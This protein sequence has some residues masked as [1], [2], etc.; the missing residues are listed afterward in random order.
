[1]I[2]PPKMPPQPPPQAGFWLRAG[3][4]SL[5]LFGIIFV[6]LLALFLSPVRP[7]GAMV[8]LFF[9]VAYVSYFTL[10]PVH[11]GGQTLGKMAAGIAIRRPD[12]SPLTYVHTFF[13]CLGYTISWLP[14]GL[15][16]LAAAVTP[17]GRA[18]HDY[19]VGTWVRETAPAGILRKT[20]VVSATLLLA[21]PLFGSM[22]LRA[23]LER[24]AKRE[25][26]V[27]A[28]P[29]P[30]PVERTARAMGKKYVPPPETRTEP[31]FKPRPPATGD[32][33]ATIHNLKRL[34][35]RR[36]AYSMRYGG[37]KPPNLKSLISVFLPE[38]PQ[39][40]TGHHPATASVQFFGKDACLRE[41]VARRAVRD[42]GAWGYVADK[43]ASCHG[44]IFVDCVH[45][46]SRRT[47]WFMH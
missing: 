18:L 32:D 33:A 43:E 11:C 45:K 37:A 41:S 3:A 9:L 20:A 30:T 44:K 12:G 31:R 7:P 13:R 24:A 47:P 38:I 1:M 2:D 39:A 14:F 40:V 28:P 29:E 10:M 42:T 5:D 26:S 46:S 27:E 4:Y 36:A 21:V 25:K 17:G 15:G 19:I 16:F 6:C 34:R 22:V 35:E 23:L 8:R